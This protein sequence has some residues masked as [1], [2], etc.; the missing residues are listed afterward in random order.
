MSKPRK[1]NNMKARMERSSKAVLR[2]NHVAVL[3]IDPDGGQFPINMKN[4]KRVTHGDRVATAV[5]DIAHQWTVYF[6]FFC[7]DQFGVRYIKSS[8]I[9]TAGVHKAEA[10][11]D[12]I[13]HHYKALRD[14]CNRR[15]IVGSAWIANPCGVSLSEE[16][17]AH[18]YDVT[19]AWAHVERTQAA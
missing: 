5:C 18:I 19:G 6:S 2:T 7:E 15:H 11:T 9:A 12:V 8:E 13:E 3:N 16:Q 10:L 17:A 14:T 1:R 4:G